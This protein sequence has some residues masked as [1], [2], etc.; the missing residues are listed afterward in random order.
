MS[1]PHCNRPVIIG[2]IGIGLKP[3]CVY[4]ATQFGYRII[5]YA[6]Q[7]ILLLGGQVKAGLQGN[8]VTMLALLCSPTFRNKNFIAL[9]GP[10]CTFFNLHLLEVVSRYRDPQL[11][12]GE[13]YLYL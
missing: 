11:Q 8:I 10:H 5:E 12:V 1:Q 13:N 6:S 4:C 3:R 9:K 2:V 7:E